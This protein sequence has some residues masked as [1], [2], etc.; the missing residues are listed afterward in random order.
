MENLKTVLGAFSIL[1]PEVIIAI[2]L[3]VNRA[4]I[5]KELNN[6]AV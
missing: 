4:F 2:V 3:V 5:R 6:E 1:T